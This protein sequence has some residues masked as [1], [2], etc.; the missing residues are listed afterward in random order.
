MITTAKEGGLRVF[1]LAGR[2]VQAVRPGEL[3]DVSYNNVDV[4]EDFRFPR[5]QR[6][7]VV[8]ASDRANDTLAVWR[9]DDAGVLRD[10]T[11]RSLMPATIFVSTTA[12]LPRT[13]SPPTAAPSTGPTTCS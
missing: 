2:L 1:D 10:V 6:A 5:Q 13:A 8:V 12:R 3:G 9:I 7:D 11:S 4:I